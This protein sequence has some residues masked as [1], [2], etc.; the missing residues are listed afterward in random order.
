MG[1]ASYNDTFQ[2]APFMPLPVCTEKFRGKNQFWE[3]T[4]TGYPKW[5]ECGFPHSAVKHHPSGTPLEIW[6]FSVSSGTFD[7]IQYL[8]IILID[9]MLIPHLR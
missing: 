1:S 9:L 5:L 2:N 8:R 6:Y 4:L 7:Y 3:N